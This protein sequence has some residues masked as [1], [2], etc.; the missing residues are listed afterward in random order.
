LVPSTNAFISNAEFLNDGTDGTDGLIDDAAVASVKV[1]HEFG[2]TGDESFRDTKALLLDQLGL[3]WLRAIAGHGGAAVDDA[4]GGD[5]HPA[6]QRVVKGAAMSADGGVFGLVFK[7]GQAAI[8]H[9]AGVSGAEIFKRPGFAADAQLSG[10]ALTVDFEPDV[11]IDEITLVQ[12]QEIGV[13]VL[14]TASDHL[15]GRFRGNA[16]EENHF[17]PPFSNSS[18]R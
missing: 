9:Q 7:F 15:Q 14:E 12:N 2:I 4:T 3:V 18:A 13:Q 17:K 6:C 8:V 1:L 10:D 5:L 11:G 16:C